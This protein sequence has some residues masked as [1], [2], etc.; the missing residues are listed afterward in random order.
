L[1]SNATY[2]WGGVKEKW[3]GSAF[4]TWYFLTEDGRF[5]KWTGSRPGSEFVSGSE[6]VATFDATYYADPSKLFD[7]PAPDGNGG[8]EGETGPIDPLV[9]AAYDLDQ[10]LGLE[11]NA[12]Y[13]WGGVREKWLGSASGTWYF[14]TEDGSFYKWTNSRPGA[15]FISG[16]E[17]V[18]TFDATY[19]M[20]PSKLFDAP[21]PAGNRV[22]VS[23]SDSADPTGLFSPQLTGAL[24]ALFVDVDRLLG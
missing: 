22:D 1:E 4:G 24:D 16:S 5:Y 18:A 17:L 21:A 8:D 7:A 20:D 11:S 6:L 19:Y 14:L 3:L 12:T 13:N 23:D 9:Q 10:S 15:E 2:D